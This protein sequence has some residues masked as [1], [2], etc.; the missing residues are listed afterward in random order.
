[1]EKLAQKVQKS[2][3]KDRKVR[4]RR[5]GWEDV[6]GDGLAKKKKKGNAFDALEGEDEEKVQ[7]RREWGDED[8]V[9]EEEGSE[10]GIDS[11]VQGEVKQA[12]VP[13]SVPL[14]AVLDDEIL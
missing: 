2:F 11:E 12:T 14:P 13:E 6:N 5:K 1:M 3:S 8:M 9:D 7:G 10:L 4:E